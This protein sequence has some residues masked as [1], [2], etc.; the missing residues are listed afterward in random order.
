MK[1]TRLKIT[2]IPEGQLF[3]WN[4][5]IYKKTGKTQAVDT[6]TGKETGFY[7]GCT[8]ILVSNDE[9]GGVK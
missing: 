4:R 7:D 8:G 5:V 1:Q 2:E 9:H 3:K 6:R